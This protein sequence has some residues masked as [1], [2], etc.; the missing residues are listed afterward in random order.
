MPNL[1]RCTSTKYLHSILCQGAAMYGELNLQNRN[2]GSLN[3]FCKK[4]KRDML[5]AK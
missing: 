3:M 5:S 1:P 2:I 4:M